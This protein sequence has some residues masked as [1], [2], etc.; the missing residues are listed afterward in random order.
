M[1]DDAIRAL[2]TLFFTSLLVLTLWLL[3]WPAATEKIRL[4]HATADVTAWVAMRDALQT[5]NRNVVAEPADVDI[6]EDLVTG[7]P[8]PPRGEADDIRVP[9]SVELTWPTERS[10]GFTLVHPEGVDPRRLTI[11]G[12][13]ARVFRIITDH[14]DLPIHDHYAVF[15]RD[16]D[17]EDKERERVGIIAPTFAGFR[18]M[19]YA[20]TRQV[21]A[22]LRN[23]NAPERWE[24]VRLTLLRLGYAGSPSGLSPTDA[25]L[26]SLQAEADPRLRSGGI[27]IFGVQLSLAQFFSSVGLLLAAVAFA[28][29]GPLIA[30]RS[31]GSRVH[32]QSWVFVVPDSR[33]GGRRM[34]DWITTLITT[35][36]TLTP[37]A[38]LFL[39]RQ[40]AADLKGLATGWLFGAGA[41]GLV[42][43]AIVFAMVSLELHRVRKEIPTK[44]AALA[45]A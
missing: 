1:V 18:N 9:L 16:N 11:A 17:P 27:T 43:S 45:H 29:M 35:V 23:D 32:G 20:G 38:I 2:H 36:W 40:S 15:M 34:L 10:E 28:M 42:F 12:A 21:D 14:G 33:Q 7:E 8:R 3:A 13:S 4:Y 44:P 30:L 25:A 41:L 6:T 39:Q 26:E 5:I 37:L 22:A 31:A 24:E 19:Q